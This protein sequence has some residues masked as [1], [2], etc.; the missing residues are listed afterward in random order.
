MINSQIRQ[1]YSLQPLGKETAG[2]LGNFPRLTRGLQLSALGS[3]GESGTEV[4]PWCPSTDL[5][6]L[7]LPG[8]FGPSYVPGTVLSTGDTKMKTA[9]LALMLLIVWGRRQYR[10]SIPNRK[11]TN[12]KCSMIRNFLSTDMT[13]KENAHWSILDF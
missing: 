12:P 1:T 9:I 2:T 13:L 8:V 3:G 10:L 6:F 11:I 5:Y 7:I 4:F